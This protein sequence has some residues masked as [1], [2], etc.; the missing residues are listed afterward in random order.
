MATA[1]NIKKLDYI[2][3]KIL[4]RM[5]P[6]APG[7]VVCIDLPDN[8]STKLCRFLKLIESED[9]YY[10]VPCDQEGYLYIESLENEISLDRWTPKDLKS[11]FS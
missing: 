9:N 10:F 2:N 4:K 7:E 6:I 3:K 5:N 8:N 1:I 11:L